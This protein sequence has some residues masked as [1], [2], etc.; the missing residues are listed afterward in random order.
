M[1]EKK[2]VSIET[3]EK[4]FE[5]Q[6]SCLFKDQ[7]AVYPDDV[8]MKDLVSYQSLLKRSKEKHSEMLEWSSDELRDNLEVLDAMESRGSFNMLMDI[9]ATDHLIEITLEEAV[10]YVIFLAGMYDTELLLR[11]EK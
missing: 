8:D 5:S 2:S 4:V 6:F 1:E 11:G 10:C 9:L 7:D 3:L